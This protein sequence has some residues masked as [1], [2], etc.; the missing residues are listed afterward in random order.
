MSHIS[1][2]I[3]SPAHTP[4]LHSFPTRRSSDLSPN[5]LRTRGDTCSPRRPNRGRSGT[6]LLGSPGTALGRTSLPPPNRASPHSCA[7]RKVRPPSLWSTSIESSD[8][9]QAQHLHR[10]ISTLM[11]ALGVDSECRGHRV[12]LH[13]P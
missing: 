5:R 4:D 10:L 9:S 1:R 8:T 12:L 6:P 11:V 7:S 2:L 3:L 13:T